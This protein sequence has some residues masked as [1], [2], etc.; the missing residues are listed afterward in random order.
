MMYNP[1][2]FLTPEVLTEVLAEF[3]W[4]E[5]FKLDDDRPDGIEICLPRCH[6][7]VTEGFESSMSLK[8]LPESTGLDHSVSLADALAALRK[9][10]ERTLPP[11]P[12]LIDYFSPQSSLDKVKNELRDL[13]T[14]LFTYFQPSLTGDFDWVATYRQHGAKSR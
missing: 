3:P 8:F 6:L 12:K 7:Y 1:P 14:L 13:C 10:P 2:T 5:P 4:P 9:D 11:R